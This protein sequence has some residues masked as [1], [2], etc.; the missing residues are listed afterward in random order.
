M[1]GNDTYVHVLIEIVQSDETIFAGFL[2]F[3]VGMAG[4][5]EDE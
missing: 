2:Q 1:A 4:K 3:D 5:G